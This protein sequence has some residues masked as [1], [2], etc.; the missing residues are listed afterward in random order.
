MVILK[1]RNGRMV[2]IR[3]HSAQCMLVI[4]PFYC[5]TNQTHRAVGKSSIYLPVEYL[6][7]SISLRPHGGPRWPPQKR[8]QNWFGIARRLGYA[9][10]G[11]AECKARL[12]VPRASFSV[13]TQFLHFPPQIEHTWLIIMHLGENCAGGSMKNKR[14]FRC[15][16]HGRAKWLKS[17][18]NASRIGR[19][20]SV[21]NQSPNH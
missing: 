4:A 17:S 2:V 9:S 19:Q 8:N 12:G 15:C 5:V 7:V 18:N 14:C 3:T 16:N 1:T 21:R 20:K 11:R 6:G 10:V 13:A